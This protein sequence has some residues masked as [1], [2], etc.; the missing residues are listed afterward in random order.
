MARGWGMDIPSEVRRRE[1]AGPFK[2]REKAERASCGE[3][4]EEMIEKAYRA[5]DRAHG[6]D[7]ESQGQTQG[8]DGEGTA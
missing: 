2:S 1:Y 6:R 7:H 4:R 5:I 8:H 3:F